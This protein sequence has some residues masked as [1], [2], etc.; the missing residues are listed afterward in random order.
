MIGQALALLHSRARL[1]RGWLQLKRL[2]ILLGASTFMVTLSS[3]SSLMDLSGNVTGA[4]TSISKTSKSTN[5]VFEIQPFEHS[6]EFT[7]GRA[8]NDFAYNLQTLSFV[9]KQAISNVDKYL[10]VNREANRQFENQSLSYNSAEL[11][12]QTFAN[13]RNTLFILGLGLPILGKNIIPTM[14]NSDGKFIYQAN[15]ESLGNGNFT[16]R[17]VRVGIV[18]GVFDNEHPSYAKQAVRVPYPAENNNADPLGLKENH[19]TYVGLIVGGKREA[20][21][22]G[23]T[24]N[25]NISYLQLHVND[26][27]LHTVYRKILATNPDIVNNSYYVPYPKPVQQLTAQ[28]N[29]PT[30]INSLPVIGNSSSLFLNAQNGLIYVAEQ[31]SPRLFVFSTGNYT[32]ADFIKRVYKTTPK[33]KLDD[34]NFGY[35]TGTYSAL[36]QLL[37]N[38]KIASTLLAV[39]GVDIDLY[40]TKKRGI[41]LTKNNI[42]AESSETRLVEQLAKEAQIPTPQPTVQFSRDQ[43][44][45]YP[46]AVQCGVIKYNCVAGSYLYEY[47]AVNP[48]DKPVVKGGTSF[49]APEV[50]A[51]AA[52]VKEQFPWMT[53]TQLKQTLL[54]TAMDLGTPGVDE[55]FGWGVVNAARALGGPSMF[56]YGDFEVNMQNASHIPMA[57][58]QPL[59]VDFSTLTEPELETWARITKTVTQKEVQGQ[60]DQDETAPGV[61]NETDSETAPAKSSST[62]P[63]KSTPTTPTTPDKSSD[64]SNIDAEMGANAGDIVF[65]VAESELNSQ[66]PQATLANVELTSWI[67]TLEI[68]LPS[69]SSSANL[70]NSGGTSS[71][72]NLSNYIAT[73]T[74]PLTTQPA[75]AASL[76]ITETRQAQHV[77][78]VGDGQNTVVVSAQ[79]VVEETT[80]S[81][82]RQEVGYN[83]FFTNNIVG[84]GGL[85]V[86]GLSKDFLYL[87]GANQYT[88]HTIVESGNLAVVGAQSLGLALK[89]QIAQ[90]NAPI[91]VQSKGSLYLYSATTKDIIN[92]GYTL[93][94]NSKVKGNLINQP[95]ATLALDLSKNNLV[96]GHVVLAGTLYIYNA[97]NYMVSTK[98]GNNLQGTVLLEA[99]NG[100]EGSFNRVIID[101]QEV[102]D[103]E[104]FNNGSKLAINLVRKNK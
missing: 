63:S 31:A 86:N 59:D 4:D 48:A 79:P 36:G 37:T 33:E 73:M 15:L 95:N 97:R 35:Q 7:R 20:G 24:P 88:G 81:L 103:F 99:T 25:A 98:E 9:D 2:P 51:I 49:S 61:G 67:N 44:Y 76:K 65:P 16:G 50:T 62:Q 101:N 84:N 39:T 58:L 41:E 56:V 78:N 70:T 77:V 66:E 23:L 91:H 104:I 85:V 69:T 1:A 6:S 87:T 54:T 83:Y 13:N 18:D 55:V 38:P 52:M 26:Q 29:E 22:P 14:E 10:S 42:R 43:I 57:L 71:T 72:N 40:G 47:P 5:Q 60:E 34:V 30:I 64:P 92:N 12:N 93:I 3:C 68:S 89:N 27:N 53:S 19:G 102:K 32:F 11:A 21:Q 82:A 90:V 17:N 94:G 75:D 80:S 46:A 100:I 28:S 8:E 96:E 74:T 45:S